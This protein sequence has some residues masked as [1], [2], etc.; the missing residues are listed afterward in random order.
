VERFLSARKIS[1]APDSEGA[2]VFRDRRIAKLKGGT[3][4]STQR[5]DFN[6]EERRR[7]NGKEGPRSKSFPMERILKNSRHVRKVEWML[8]RLGKKQEK[9]AASPGGDQD[10]LP[11]LLAFL[12]KE[13]KKVYLCKK[14]RRR[15]AGKEAG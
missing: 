6:P 1:E 11:D 14:T 10:T 15:L 9:E 2:R 8:E 12:K 5:Q 4:T 3:H 13:R 7:R